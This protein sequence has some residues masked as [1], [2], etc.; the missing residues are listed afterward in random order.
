MSKIV[1]NEL[2]KY[3]KLSLQRWEDEN[4][5]YEEQ[6]KNNELTDKEKEQ[7]KLALT[8]TILQKF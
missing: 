5:E 1:K 7:K 3:R 4:R 2:L 6:V 8:P